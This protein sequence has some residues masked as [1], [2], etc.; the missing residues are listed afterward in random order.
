MFETPDELATLDTLLA[1]SFGRAG[2]HLTSIIATDRRLSA[3][4][5]ARYLVG[6]RHLV[7][8]TITQNDEP[9]CSAVDGLFL[10]GRF[11][12][13][14]SAESFKARHLERRPALSAAHV[15]GED[16]GVFV[17]GDARVVRGGPGEADAIRH[18]WS[19]IYDSSPEDW[20][21]NP[22]DA[23]YIE[24][25]PTSM[26]SYAFSRERFEALCERADPDE[27]SDAPSSVALDGG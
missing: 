3:A 25:V 11:W 24:I 9:R 13:S 14:T 12:F 23:R 5:L 19:E 15:V 17:H 16:V 10:H 8:A 4:D 7:V 26:Y 2:D 6:V 20:V 21:A 22:G 27:S 1:A 18:Y